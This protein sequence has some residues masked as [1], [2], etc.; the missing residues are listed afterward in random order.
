M[1]R[2]FTLLSA[3]VGAAVVTAFV[4]ASGPRPGGLAG[5]SVVLGALVLATLCSW[6]FEKDLDD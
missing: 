5:A 6:V 2:T 4:A 1:G 3:T